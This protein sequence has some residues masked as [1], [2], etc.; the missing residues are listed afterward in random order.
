MSDHD[1]D[2]MER[3]AT[4]FRK[5]T[6]RTA[7]LVGKAGWSALFAGRKKKPAS[8]SDDETAKAV[9]K[10]SALADDLDELKGLMM[11]FGQMASY[12]NASLPPAAQ[13]ALARL[14]ASSRPME[15]EAV[16]AVIASDL[17]ASGEALFDEIE[18]Q[19]F[20]AASIGQVHRARLRGAPVAVKVQ[21]PAIEKA[22]TSD[23]KT[24]GRLTRLATMLMPVSGRQLVEELR[25]RSLE[26]CDYTREAANQALFARLFARV[27]GAS[28]PAVVSERSGRRVLTTSLVEGRQTFYPFIEGADEATRSRAGLTIYR[29][30]MQTLFERCVFNADPHPGNYLFT[31]GGEVTF[32]DFG[33]VRYFDAAFIDTW[34]RLAKSIRADDHAEFRAAFLQTGLVEKPKRFDWDHQWQVMHYLYEPML[35]TG[36][37]RFTQDYVKQSY[38]LMI[39]NNPNKRRVGMPAEWLFLNRLQWGLNSI[40]AHLGARGRFA[41]IFWAAVD[42]DTRPVGDASA[43][44]GAQAQVKPQAAAVA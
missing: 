12:L 3:L 15:W 23:L 33:C 18:R 20:A 17:G 28:V 4:G 27:P 13:E 34:K 6:L 24:L 32:L 10:A 5:R 37:Y 26:E 30:C 43:D 1:P 25:A 44:V 36:P 38:D 2:P 31:P 42:S 22:L 9:K 7:R 11:K 40:L 19:P 14:Q 16:D 41:D 21:H 29:A 8:V 39:W 35:A